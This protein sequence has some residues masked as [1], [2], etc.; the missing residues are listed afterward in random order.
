MEPT[1]LVSK[2]CPKIGDLGS[3]FYFDS[4]TLAKGK[5]LGLDGF[6]FY[7]L[8]RGGVLGDVEA[9]VVQSAFGYFA[10]GLVGK[11]WSTA[12]EVMPPRDAGR[13]YLA[14][15]QEFGRRKFSA[16]D[17]LD[18]FCEAAGAINDAADPASLALYAAASAEP[19]CDDL[20]GRAMQLVTV[21]RE[22]RG[23]AHLA[24]I[25]TLNLD[26]G[27]AHAIKRPDDVS[28][29][30][31]AEPPAITDE[32]RALHTRAEEFTDQ[33]VLGAYSAVDAD[34]AAALMAGLEAMEAAVAG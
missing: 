13:A 2:A 3:A 8:G 23:S 32:H 4:E 22:Y 14:C 21:L 7:F 33:M 31:Y 6:R 1:E 18:A 30:G 10:P 27:V 26:A 15:A 17:G 29:F 24:A 34:G 12:K 20:P 5:E 28:T 16:I 25:R 11:I 9:R 19:L